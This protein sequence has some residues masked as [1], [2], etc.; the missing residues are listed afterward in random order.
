ML[1]EGRETID[2]EWLS[3]NDRMISFYDYIINSTK[4]QEVENEGN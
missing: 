1:L 2:R 3:G 4:K